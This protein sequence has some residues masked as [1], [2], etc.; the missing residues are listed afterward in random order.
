MAM[1]REEVVRV[2]TLNAWG[3]FAQ[4]SARL[5]IMRRR[6]AAVDADVLLLQ[7]V[8][9]DA[10]GDQAREVATYLRYPNVIWIEGHQV[11]GGSEGLA[12]LSRFPLA[13]VRVDDLPASEPP[14]RMLS[15]ALTKGGTSIRVVCAHTVAVPEDARLRQVAAVLACRDERVIIGGDLNAP[16]EE[17]LPLA[18]AAQLEDSLAGAPTPTWPVCDVTFGDSW[19]AEFGRAPHFSLHPRRLDYVLTRALRVAN[20]GVEVLGDAAEGYA[21]D[22]AV[23]WADIELSATQGA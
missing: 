3:R 16:P 7:E 5:Q 10:H 17:I 2:A 12:I 15:A 4:W 14:R 19:T 11:L 23:V 20:A 13:D 9:A 6:W 8:C 1:R 18:A 22:H 21:S